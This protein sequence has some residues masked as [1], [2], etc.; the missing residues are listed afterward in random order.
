MVDCPLRCSLMIVLNVVR[1]NENVP[2]VKHPS[3]LCN[4]SSNFRADSRFRFTF[5]KR[6][7]FRERLCLR[8]FLRRNDDPWRF[9]TTTTDGE[10]RFHREKFQIHAGN[11]QAIIGW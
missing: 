10:G 3:G 1:T 6:S 11:E 5:F 4:L 9:G 7:L 8:R 2:W